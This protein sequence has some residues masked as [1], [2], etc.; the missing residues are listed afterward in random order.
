MAAKVKLLAVLLQEKISLAK[1]SYESSLINN[2][3]LANNNKIYSYI[4]NITKPRSIPSTAHFN[5]LVASS[6]SDLFNYYF[7][8]VFTNTSS[9]PSINDLPDLSYIIN[10]IKF[11]EMEVYDD[12]IQTKHQVLMIFH[13][14]YYNHILKSCSDH[15]IICLLFH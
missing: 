12:L 10:S 6:D 9:L 5:S 7:H 11:I 15:C 1:D 2:F 3:A 8:S 13:P 14:E 4:R